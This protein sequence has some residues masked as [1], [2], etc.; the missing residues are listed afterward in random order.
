[1]TTSIRD[2]YHDAAAKKGTCMDCH[3]AE[4]A[5]GK[6]VPVKCTECHKKSNT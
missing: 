6:A 4:A 5:A 3:V 1:M 2:A